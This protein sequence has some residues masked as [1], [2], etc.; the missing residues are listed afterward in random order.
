M[1]TVVI[2]A[3]VDPAT[4]K[5]ARILAAMRGVKRQDVVKNALE[6]ELA[7]APELPTINRLTALVQN[8]AVHHV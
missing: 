8:E 6:R 5:A 7:N 1:V 3:R 2:S 4:D